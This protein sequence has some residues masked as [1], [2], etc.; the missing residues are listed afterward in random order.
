MAAV[1]VCSFAALAALA[2]LLTRPNRLYSENV[3]LP[4]YTYARYVPTPPK[5]STASDCEVR[6]VSLAF[7]SRVRKSLQESL[8]SIASNVDMNSPKGLWVGADQARLLLLQALENVSAACIASYKSSAQGAEQLFART[9]EDLNGRYDQA[10]ISNHRR[11]EPPDVT[12]RREEG[13]GF[14]VVSIV[15]GINGNLQPLPNTGMRESVRQV[16]QGLLPRRVDDLASLEVVWSPS[17][18]QDRL[19]SAEMAVLYPELRPIDGAGPMGRMLCTTCKSVYAKELGECPACGATE[20][21]TSLLS[22]KQKA[23]LSQGASASHMINCPYC[24][25]PTPSYEVQ[26]QHCGGRVKT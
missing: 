13:A 7:D 5:R 23:Q 24:A 1:F 22:A 17:V 19:S 16:L 2:Y 20:A 9:C 15:V 8:D 6:R 21:V 14:V 3:P 11:S 4:P 25:K 10:T 12:A 26:C 18:D